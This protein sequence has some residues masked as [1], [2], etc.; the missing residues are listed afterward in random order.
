MNTFEV[1]HHLKIKEEILSAIQKRMDNLSEVDRFIKEL[2]YLDWY[3][4]YSDD[5]GVYRSG[6]NRIAE[7][8]ERSKEYGLEFVFNMT[9]DKRNEWFSNQQYVKDRKKQNAIRQDEIYKL[10]SYGLSAASISRWMELREEIG[11]FLFKLPINN[12]GE[13]IYTKTTPLKEFRE[14]SL[15]TGYKGIS[16]SHE[17]QLTVYEFM[18]KLTD[19]DKRIL[20]LLAKDVLHNAVTKAG[21]IYFS[22]SDGL[23]GNMHAPFDVLRLFDGYNRHYYLVV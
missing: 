22:Y 12:G 13:F 2:Y 15:E 1:K 17:T 23:D 9:D 20:R 16:C 7:Y 6:C 11:G 21:K 3:Y 8:K 19:G 4:S 14:W 5:G 18:D 10:H